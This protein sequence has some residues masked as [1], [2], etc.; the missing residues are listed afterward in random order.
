MSAVAAVYDR[1]NSDNGAHRACY[2]PDI[3]PTKSSG[4]GARNTFHSPDRGCRKPSFQACN[5]CRGN[6]FANFGA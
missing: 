6:F 3:A 5:I 1:R 4:K 2:S